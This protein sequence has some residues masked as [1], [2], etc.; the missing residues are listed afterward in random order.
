M[1]KLETLVMSD[2]DI[3]KYFIPIDDLTPEYYQEYYSKVLPYL[4]NFYNQGNGYRPIVIGRNISWWI[5]HKEVRRRCGYSANCKRVNPPGSVCLHNTLT[6]FLTSKLSCWMCEVIGEEINP[7]TGKMRQKKCSAVWDRYYSFRPLL[8]YT[9]G[10]L[11]SMTGKLKTIRSLYW[12]PAM[13]D[14]KLLQVPVNKEW[15]EI[16]DLN[17]VIDVDI[18]NKHTNSIFEDK[19]WKHLPSF[20]DDVV[21]FI[22]NR[23]FDCKLQF[24]GNGI[25]FIT[26]K[27]LGNEKILETMTREQFWNRVA[28]A[29]RDF[30]NND[31]KPFVDEKYPMFDIDGEEPYTMKFYKAPFSLHQRLNTVAIPLS[32]E[33]LD[34]T[35]EQF[36]EICKPEYVCEHIVDIKKVWE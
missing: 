14:I 17:L 26:G 16:V 11:K 31:L 35:A 29:W 7:K 13:R 8:Y 6:Q 3:I 28:G 20:V 24:S 34:K 4:E 33:M 25:Y 27:V 15:S 23:G 22:E 9:I 18:K 5:Q 1:T 32:R 30:L 19:Y 36:Q 10:Q 21:G 12:Q 2:E